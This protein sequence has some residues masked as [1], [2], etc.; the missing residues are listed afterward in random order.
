ME[1]GAGRRAQGDALD[2]GVGIRVHVRIG[3]RVE[4]GQTLL[5]L[6][7]NERAG[8][9]LPPGWITLGDTPCEPIPW[10]LGTVEV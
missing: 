2:L 8:N 9:P 4:P 1:L 5:T 6:H 10:L 7:C 3:Q